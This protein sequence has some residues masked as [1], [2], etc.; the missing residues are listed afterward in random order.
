MLGN[1]HNVFIDIDYY[2]GYVIGFELCKLYNVDI[3]KLT[4]LWLT[5]CVNNDNNIDPT[6]KALVEME[7]AI[8]KKDDT[9]KLSNSTKE[10]DAEPQQNTTDEH[11]I[12][13]EALYPL[14]F[15]QIFIILTHS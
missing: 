11:F 9:Q 1:K 8:L 3:E 13:N 2:N 6:V 4:E 10:N 15:Y 5:F 12:K 14:T 7:N